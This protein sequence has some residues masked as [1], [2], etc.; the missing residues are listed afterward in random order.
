MKKWTPVIV[1]W[2]DAV[3]YHD[4]AKSTDDFPAAERCSSGFFLKR[5]AAGDIT[6]C[7]E[8]DRKSKNDASDCQT[9]TTIL[10]GMILEIVE[11]EPKRKR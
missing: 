2:R 4:P 7:M 9:I 8:D 6:I 3:T 11:L 5:N 10:S 1:T